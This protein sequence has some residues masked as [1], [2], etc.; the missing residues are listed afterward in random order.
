MPEDNKMTAVGKLE[1]L[2]DLWMGGADS[3]CFG[4]EGIKWHVMCFCKHSLELCKRMWISLKI[5]AIP[6]EVE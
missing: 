5:F 2:P 1:F 3:L 4:V 6:S